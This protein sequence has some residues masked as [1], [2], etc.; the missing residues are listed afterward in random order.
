MP[1]GI[2]P[3]SSFHEESRDSSSFKLPILSGIVLDR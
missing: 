1:E 3:D 2:E